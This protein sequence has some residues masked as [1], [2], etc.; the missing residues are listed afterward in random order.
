MWTKHDSDRVREVNS[1]L[2]RHS[3]LHGR[4]AGFGTAVNATKL[5]FL[6]DLLASMVR[7]AEEKKAEKAVS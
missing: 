1:S 6:F 2:H 3:I 5:L 4:S 7:R